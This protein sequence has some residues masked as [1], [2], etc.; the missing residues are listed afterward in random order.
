[1]ATH[2]KH[3]ITKFLTQYKYDTNTKENIS[4]IVYSIIDKKLHPYVKL[5]KIYQNKVILYVDY[6]V[7]GYE[8]NLSKER[9]IRE[10][11][12]IYPHIET[13]IVKPQK[14]I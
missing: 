12:K 9:I 6:S 10:L 14:H 8:V 13:I 11:N 1:M 5:G 4:E 2:I 3:L 7:V